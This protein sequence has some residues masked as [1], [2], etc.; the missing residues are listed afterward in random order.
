MEN[1]TD[2]VRELRTVFSR[3]KEH[4]VEADLLL[5]DY[6]PEIGKIL[7]C[8]MEL[9]QEDVTL[10]ADKIS[11]SGAARVRLLY[12]S[13]S[14][15]LRC[16]EN[17]VKYT[18]LI[19]G[20]GFETGDICL[21]RQRVTD[22]NFRAVSPRKVEVRASAAITAEVKRLQEI[23]F[24]CGGDD[25][26]VQFK[27]AETPC[28]RLSAFSALGFE[29]N[30][31]ISLPL[32]K[33]SIRSVLRT[34]ASVSW[35]EIAVINNKVKL[36]GAAEVTFAVIT[37]DN[38]VSGEHTVSLPFT[39]VKDLYGALEHDV[40]TC[41]LR[42]AEAVLDLKESGDAR[43]GGVTVRVNVLLAAW[44]SDSCSYVAD[45]FS[46]EAELALKK[47]ELSLLQEAA[48][49]TDVAE[50]SGELQTYETQAT[51]LCDKTVTDIGYALFEDQDGRRLNGSMTLR[52]LL[53]DKEN[54]YCCVSRSCSFAAALPEA[55][56]GTEEIAVSLNGLSADLVADGKIKY[57]GT[58]R[59]NVLRLRENVA[60]AV[61]GMERG[62]AFRK[63]DREKIVLYYGEPGENVWEIAK[64]NRTSVSAL[65]ELNGMEEDVLQ[66]K[67]LLI[68]KA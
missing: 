58:L 60:E 30:E 19:D 68:F 43:E 47:T 15:E 33:D 57:R 9:S 46:P 13:E 20:G 49:T 11:L 40:C 66:N 12:A 1:Q 63:P 17:T 25:P 53:R 48:E 2:T 39:Q 21:I 44:R 24:L 37:E 41:H 36:S 23:P 22:L 65:K 6:Y 16:Y 61:S 64:E 3:I 8:S 67:K 7:D 55:F 34:A 18:K 62:E 56:T 28:L 26:A 50:F 35:T 51:E 4:S 54:A 31:K 27:T 59:L 10:T 29:L 5:P 52:L 38:L 45:A 42:S 14:G 32:P